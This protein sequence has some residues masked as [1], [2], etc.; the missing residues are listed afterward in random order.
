MPENI[1][2]EQV[3]KFFSINICMIR[4]KVMFVG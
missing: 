3:G 4:G 2:D 1:H